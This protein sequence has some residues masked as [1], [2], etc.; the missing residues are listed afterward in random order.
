[1]AQPDPNIAD[2]AGLIGKLGG[3]ASSALAPQQALK[4][5]ER[6]AASPDAALTRRI[7]AENVFRR[8]RGFALAFALTAL[9]AA[10]TSGVAYMVG[11]VVNLT[12]QR[13]SY[14][15]VMILSLALVALFTVRGLASYGSAVIVAGIGNNITAET[16]RRIFDRLLDQRLDFLADR[17]SADFMANAIVGAAAVSNVV[18]ILVMALGRD[19]LSLIALTA[20]MIWQDPILS[21]LGVV[22]TPL[23]L[24]LV[25]KLM[26]RVRRIASTEFVGSAL[27]LR[28][29]QETIQGFKV[30]KAFNLEDAIRA[31]AAGNIAALEK[32]ANKMARVSN[33]ASPMIEALGGAAIGIACLYSG[34]RVLRM[35]ATPGELVSFMTAFLLA[36]EPARRLARVNID[37]TANL[38]AARGLYA[39]F[40]TPRPEREDADKSP[41]IATAGRIVMSDVHFGYRAGE[42]VLR[43]LSLVAEPGRLTALVGASGGGKSTVFNLL[44][45]FYE[46]G[47]GTITIDGQAVAEHSRSSIRAQISYVGQDIYL[48]HGTIR[49][50]I[51]IGKPDASEAELVAAAEAAFAHDFIVAMPQGFDTAV[52]EGGSQL[53]LGQRQRISLARAFIKDAP[54]VLLDEPTASLD[55]ESEHHVQAAIRRLCAG[56]TTLAIAHRLNTIRD[57]SC[58]HVIDAGRVVES[59]THER[60]MQDGGIY[61]RYVNLQFPDRQATLPGF[62]SEPGT[63]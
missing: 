39:L 53:S 24:L 26:V 17:H 57:A 32:A 38:V 16:Q 51:L 43:G 62:F 41:L 9:A 56:K 11:S 35:N 50:N 3:W 6:F 52:G 1:M 31:R 19:L 55:P 12:F 13:S 21:L 49:D 28:T 14:H 63:K 30:V 7:L 37:L 29:M 42:P 22:V 36:F 5:L 18:N 4:L 2:D 44:L 34:Y 23:A 10:C 45:R 25:Q 58:V 48:F 8:W 46:A 27:M 61:A 20:V 33:R 40:D 15:E 59:G 60:L 54:V 47:A